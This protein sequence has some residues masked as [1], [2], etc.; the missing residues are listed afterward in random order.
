MGQRIR[1]R[2]YGKAK[3][4]AIRR[5]RKTPKKKRKRYRIRRK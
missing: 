1:E 4:L 2:K 3:K 5:N